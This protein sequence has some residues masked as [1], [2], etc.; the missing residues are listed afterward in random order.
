MVGCEGHRV[1]C[2]LVHAEHMLDAVS[3]AFC[4]LILQSGY[5]GEPR[6]LYADAFV[7]SVHSVRVR[8]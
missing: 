5:S 2:E 6:A 8:V 4:S 3:N 1:D 7:A